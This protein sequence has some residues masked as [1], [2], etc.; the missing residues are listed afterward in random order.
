MYLFLTTTTTLFCYLLFLES[1]HGRVELAKALIIGYFCPV[2]SNH[3]MMLR[4]TGTLLNSWR[5]QAGSSTECSNSHPE[6]KVNRFWAK[7]TNVAV[8]VDDDELLLAKVSKKQQE[9]FKALHLDV[10]GWWILPPAVYLLLLQP[11][12]P[13]QFEASF[14]LSSSASPAVSRAST[15]ASSRGRFKDT[16]CGSSSESSRGG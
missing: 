11:A 6:N 12:G 10:N 7:K 15:L 5:T 4:I 3:V 1:Q 2:V 16:P 13:A 14:S 8:C 9:L